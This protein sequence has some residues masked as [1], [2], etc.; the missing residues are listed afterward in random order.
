MIVFNSVEI[1]RSKRTS[2]Q[3]DV[4][5]ANVWVYIA[6]GSFGVYVLFSVPLLFIAE[7]WRSFAAQAIFIL[8]LIFQLVAPRFQNIDEQGVGDKRIRIIIGCLLIVSSI[9]LAIWFVSL[10]FAAPGAWIFILNA[11]VIGGVGI[12]FGVRN[13]VLGIRA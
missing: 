1:V 6:L 12:L 2:P 7:P 4:F 3:A 5:P 8:A 9:G 11:V 10:W 13:L